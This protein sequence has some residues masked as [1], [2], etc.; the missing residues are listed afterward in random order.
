MQL[1]DLLVS[2][3]WRN[4]HHVNEH[5]H[6]LPDTLAEM[7]LASRIE[8]KKGLSIVVGDVYVLTSIDFTTVR[9]DE[10]RVKIRQVKTKA[11]QNPLMAPPSIVTSSLAEA[12]AEFTSGSKRPP[13]ARNYSGPY[14][15]DNNTS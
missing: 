9:R 7:G 3:I 14:D 12:H 5:R 2:L 13:V 1:P 10:S 6:E 8:G 11:S 15:P 4:R